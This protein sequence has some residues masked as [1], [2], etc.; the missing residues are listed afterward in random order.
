MTK[1][2]PLNACAAAIGG[3][4]LAMMI[5]AH[6]AAM[7]PMKGAADRLWS[8]LVIAGI[9]IAMTPLTAD[10]VLMH[11]EQGSHSQRSP[12]FKRLEGAQWA[13]TPWRDLG[14]YNIRVPL[15]LMSEVVANE[16]GADGHVHGVCRQLRQKW[17][18]TRGFRT[19]MNPP[20]NSDQRV[21]LSRDW[22]CPP[23]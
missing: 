5:A 13:T 6:A 15:L 18:L 7:G 14:F 17:P 20:R 11:E 1:V 10:M 4:W 2:P 12:V 8:L 3:L 19:E 9:D 21:G 16:W 22:I 23:P